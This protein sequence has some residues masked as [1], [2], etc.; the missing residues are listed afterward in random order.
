MVRSRNFYVPTYVNFA[1]VNETVSCV[2]V[3]AA[4]G[5]TTGRYCGIPLG[6]SNVNV[7]VN[8]LHTVDFR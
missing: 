7:I 4:R 8:L 5:S 3:K 2:N 1:H 6:I